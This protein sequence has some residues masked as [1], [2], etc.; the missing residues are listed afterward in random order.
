M[1]SKTYS[2]EEIQRLAMSDDL[3]MPESISLEPEGKSLTVRLP[4]KF[5][6][7]NKKSLITIPAFN[8]D[9]EYEK[10]FLLL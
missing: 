8:E 3:F 1:I 9:L 10:E 2:T 5:K 7:L 6:H 4:D